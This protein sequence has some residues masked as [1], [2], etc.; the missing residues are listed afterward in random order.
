MYEDLNKEQRAAVEHTEGPVLVFAGAGSGK[1]RVLTYRIANLIENH[2]VSPYNIMAVTFTNKA[3]GEIKERLKGLIKRDLNG[4]WAGTFH[5]MCCR[6]L[7]ES[8]ES[9]GVPKNFVIYDDGDSLSVIKDAMELLDLDPKRYN[10][11]AIAGVISR[12]KEELVKAADFGNRFAGDLESAAGDVYEIYERELAT[13]HALDFDDLIMKAVEM[14]DAVPEIRQRYA[15]KFHYILVDEYQDINITQYMLVRLLSSVH[16]NVFC[17]GDDD[18]SIYRWRGAKVGIILRFEQ[19]FP[20]AAV[21]KLEQNYRSTKNILAAAQAVVEKNSIRA[22][23]H[24]RTDNPAGDRIGYVSANSDLDEASMVAQGIHEKVDYGSDNYRDIAVLYRMNSQS[25]LL[26]EALINR[27]IP[28]KIIGSV[29][30][31]DRKEIKDIIAYLR[32]A[33]SPYESVSFKRVVNVPARGFGLTSLARVENYAAAHECSLYEAAKDMDSIIGLTARVKS[34]LE[35]F[36]TIIERLRD[37]VGK[38]GLFALTEELLNLTGYVTMLKDEGTSEAQSKLENIEEFMN[39]VSR[40]A[41][42]GGD[43]TL[44]NFLEQIALISDIDSYD[45]GENAV[46]LM[47]MHAAKGLEFPVVYIPGM[48]E[49]VFPNARAFADPE[50]MEEERRLC[51]VGM[52]RAMKN[53]TLTHAEQRMVYGKLTRMLPSRFIGDVPRSLLD[54]PEAPARPTY[55]EVSERAPYRTFNPT[56]VRKPAAVSGGEP[57]FKPAQ[58][59]RHDKFGKGVI[60]AVNGE[61]DNEQ[62]SVLFDEAGKKNLLVSVAKSKMRVIH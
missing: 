47:T 3:A 21:Y 43:A 16:G 32:L 5:G 29:R 13:N 14:L 49:S 25:R 2:K 8:G 6:M 51:Y 31:Y 28:Y 42:G 52:T 10:P 48:D 9:I 53:L 30:F 44:G 56:V 60:L 1:T 26:E 22:D 45:N 55:S 54:L 4:M 11:R 58:K 38:M 40:F 61:G 7:R 24:L 37:A 34:A 46:T 35:S 62:V 41:D 27:R 33:A 19:D 59:V 50:E 36:L 15:E 39:V 18:Q 57:T 12:A 20:K 17:V 23:K